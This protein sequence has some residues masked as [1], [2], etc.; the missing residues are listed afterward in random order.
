M[1]EEN[2]VAETVKDEAAQPDMGATG[3]PAETPDKTEPDWKAL[4]RKHE[5]AEK[6]NYKMAQDLQA[7][8]AERDAQIARLNAR[9]AHPELTESDFEMCGATSADEITA[10]ADKFAARISTPDATAAKDAATPGDEAPREKQPVPPTPAYL[11]AVAASQG[12]PTA[13]RGSGDS[14]AEIYKKTKNSIKLD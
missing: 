2:T 6:R 5:D 4:S 14:P 8:V 7:T 10:W 1:N 13:K 12:A 11:S 9:L 3:T